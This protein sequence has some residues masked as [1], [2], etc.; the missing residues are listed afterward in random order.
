MGNFL[1]LFKILLPLIDLENPAK[2]SLFKIFPLMLLY[3]GNSGVM[4]FISEK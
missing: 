1:C 3:I 4:R 2:R